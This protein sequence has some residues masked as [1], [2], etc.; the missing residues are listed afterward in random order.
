M[1]F[2]SIASMLEA[3]KSAD[4]PL[5][6]VICE[7]DC[8]ENNYT[9]EASHRQ[10]QTLWEAMQQSSKQYCASDRS[11]S[12]FIGGD[13]EKLRLAAQ[14]GALIGGTYLLRV[15]EE[16]LKV[17]EC[18]ACMKRIVAAPTAGKLR[19]APRRSASADGRKAAG[20]GGDLA[21]AV[22]R[23]RLRTGHGDTRQCRRSGRRLSGGNRHCQCHGSCRTDAYFR[24]NRRTMRPCVCDVSWQFARLD[25]R[26]GWPDS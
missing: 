4:K 23:R 6:T 7:D 11:N 8:Q 15:I 24:R 2:S 25:L 20:H 26:S 21:G 5:Y 14:A 12:G 18:N 19:R 13:A 9:E 1:S 22:H 3:A 16:A 17:A 10:I